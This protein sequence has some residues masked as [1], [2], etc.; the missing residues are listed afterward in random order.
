MISQDMKSQVRNW[1][2]EA[3]ERIPKEI[4]KQIEHVGGESMLLERI[5]ILHWVYFNRETLKMYQEALRLLDGDSAFDETLVN[6]A[7]QRNKCAY[8]SMLENITHLKKSISE[9]ET[10]LSGLEER[11]PMYGVTADVLEKMLKE[12]HDGNPEN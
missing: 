7:V 4:N 12:Y 10:C 2:M 1:F 6:A 5:D 9:M 11:M 3:V 8:S